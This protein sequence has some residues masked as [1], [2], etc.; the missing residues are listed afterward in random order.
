MRQQQFL[1]VLERDE[2]ESRWRAVLEI[3]TLPAET[4]PLEDALGRVLAADVR[5]EVDVPGFDRA[6]MDGFA[7]RAEDT[8][9]ATEAEPVLLELNSESIPTGVDPTE[10]VKPGTATS[11][12][13]GGM[14]P[15]GADA[16]L[17]VEFTDV[18]RSAI[19]SRRE[20]VPG[21]AVSFA[22]TDIGWGET[23][24]FGGTQ[25][26]SRETG[27]LAA[28]GRSEVSVVRRP[29]VAIL[30]TGDEII[31][32]GETMRPGLVFDSNGRI[33]ADAVRELGAEPRFLGVFRDEEVGLLKRVAE[34]ARDLGCPVVR[35]YGGHVN[36]EIGRRESWLRTEGLKDAG[37]FAAEIGVRLAIETHG[38]TM[39]LSASE[40]SSMV[41]E[42]GLKNVGILLDYAW[43]HLAGRESPDAVL[44]L[45]LPRTF[46]NSSVAFPYVL[47]SRRWTSAWSK[48]VFR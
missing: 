8:F 29:R 16:V 12:A 6:N 23:V 46:L 10:E 11:I 22:G 47:P 5:A 30:S 39:T 42:V 38:G 33:L 3:A 41:E 43:V 20:R 36:E 18:D 7:V 28:I 19:V 40:A 32:P 4:V 1:E 9:G 25:L 27:V 15:R 31:Q 13:T 21:A 2:A 24:V 44:R 14:L 48:R 35:A 26:T 34:I 17:P 45:A 37:E